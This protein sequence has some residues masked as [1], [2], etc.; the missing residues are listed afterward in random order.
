MKRL[1]VI[2]LV[3]III[4]LPISSMAFD[5]T[6][7]EETG[8]KLYELPNGVKDE[9]IDGKLVQRVKQVIVTGEDIFSVST[10]TNVQDVAFKTPDSVRYYYGISGEAN[11]SGRDEVS[12]E[13]RD[14]IS[15]IG[16]FYTN[17]GAG[18]TD[19]YIRILLDKNLYPTQQDCINFFNENPQNIIYQLETPIEYNIE[20]IKGQHKVKLLINEFSSHIKNI[21]IAISKT[22][23]E[24]FYD[25]EAITARGI[26]FF[27]YVATVFCLSILAIVFKRR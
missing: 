6:V 21:A 1:T 7:D 5:Y 23:T 9:I 2:L 13:D 14:L 15:S 22:V 19:N 10:R 11:V 27:A 17:V 3:L 12:A 24:F 8:I 18:T 26:L 4:V 25:G 20:P 16:K